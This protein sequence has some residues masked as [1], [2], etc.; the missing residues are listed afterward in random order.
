MITTK[1]NKP[2]NRLITACAFAA[3]TL[4]LSGI[5]MT[6]AQADETCHHPTWLKLSVKKILFTFGPWV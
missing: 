5:G 1:K 3:S 2:L 4:A 6:S